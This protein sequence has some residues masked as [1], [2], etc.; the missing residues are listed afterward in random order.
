MSWNPTGSH[1]SESELKALRGGVEKLE[2]AC[3]KGFSDNV[4]AT[5]EEYQET[6]KGISDDIIKSLGNTNRAL[7][8]LLADKATPEKA[9]P[10]G[11]R[12]TREYGT[13]SGSSSGIEHDGGSISAEEKKEARE[14]RKAR[15]DR[16]DSSKNKVVGDCQD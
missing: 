8:K 10:R 16:E 14:L 7:S 9:S 2:G 13:P 4:A 6:H 11:V 5:K 15:Q 3:N 1:G 12:R